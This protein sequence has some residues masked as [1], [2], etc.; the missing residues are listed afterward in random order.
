[1]EAIQI[2]GTGPQR[3]GVYK[4]WFYKGSG[5]VLGF[6]LDARRSVQSQTLGSGASR[7][8]R[9]AAKSRRP[10]HGQNQ[11]A[12][13]RTRGAGHSLTAAWNLVLGL[14]YV[15]STFTMA[16]KPPLSVRE[17]PSLR[18]V[19]LVR[20]APGAPSS[21]SAYCSKALGASWGLSCSWQS[22]L[23]AYTTET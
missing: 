3:R 15:Y 22:L 1:M 9:A 12:R 11:A 14:E 4:N 13:C 20:P 7:T 8:P 23:L 10:A 16:P 5:P 21:A 19:T 17:T 2:W 18:P 6:I